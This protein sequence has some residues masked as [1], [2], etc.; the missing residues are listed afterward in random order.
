M[1]LMWREM[2]KR[3][4]VRHSFYNTAALYLVTSD[5]LAS[6]AVR[7]AIITQ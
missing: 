2:Q 5:K 1:P 3:T 4:Q 7:Y 6:N